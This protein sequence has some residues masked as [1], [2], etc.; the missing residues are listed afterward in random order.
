M[1]TGS[2]ILT[3]HLERNN[4][5][6]HDNDSRYASTILTG[7]SVTAMPLRSCTREFSSHEHGTVG[8]AEGFA[9][10]AGCAYQAH[11]A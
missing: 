6:V 7:K 11:G 4:G 2:L 10:R 5:I 3:G 9:A 1:S 8:G